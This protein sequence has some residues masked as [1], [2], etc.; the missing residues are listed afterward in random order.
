[1]AKSIEEKVV[2]AI[3]NAVMDTRFRYSEF[4]RLMSDRSP[5]TYMAFLN[6]IAG[7]MAYLAVYDDYNYYPNGHERDAPLAAEL[8]DI[9]QTW[10]EGLDE[11]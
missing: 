9:L 10:A 7:Y 2:D 11:S 8:R 1:M 6:L 5:A 3:E 4:S